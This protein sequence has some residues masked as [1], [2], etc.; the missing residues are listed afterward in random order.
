MISVMSLIRMA[1]QFFKKYS[2]SLQRNKLLRNKT[3]EIVGREFLRL[4]QEWKI[5]T[6]F[7]V[8][9]DTQGPSS[10]HLELYKTH[11]E[12]ITISDTQT[13]IMNIRLGIS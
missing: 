12:L 2:P 4:T 11:L 13:D 1:L 7:L 5:G 3:S 6:H 8:P 10:E 9:G